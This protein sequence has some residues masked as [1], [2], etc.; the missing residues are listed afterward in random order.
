ML[1]FEASLIFQEP[2]CTFVIPDSRHSTFSI[3]ITNA[4]FIGEKVHYIIVFTPHRYPKS[5]Y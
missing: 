5:G 4:V 3:V 2:L 1:Y